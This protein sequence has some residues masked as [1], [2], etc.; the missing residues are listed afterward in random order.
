MLT[1]DYVI[2]YRVLTLFWPTCAGNEAASIGLLLSQTASERVKNQDREKEFRW[3]I[4]CLKSVK[5][6]VV[7]KLIRQLFGLQQ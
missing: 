3:P 7:K 5:T 1:R 2:D 6:D 4:T